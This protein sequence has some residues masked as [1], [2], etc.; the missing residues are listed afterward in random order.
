VAVAVR[1]GGGEGVDRGRV[2][3][4]QGQGGGADLLGQRAEAVGAAGAGDDVEAGPGQLAGA[5][6]PDPAGGPG[7]D[8]DPLGLPSVGLLSA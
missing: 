6:R 8:G 7:D 5:G 4:V 3:D 2:G 1:D